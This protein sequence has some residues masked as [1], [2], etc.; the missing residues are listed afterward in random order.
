MGRFN[1][2]SFG[3]VPRDVMAE[4]HRLQEQCEDDPDAWIG[5]GYRA[6]VQE[7]RGVLA[8][9]VGAEEE[10]LVL[11]ENASGGI[12]AFLRSLPLVAGDKILFPSTTYGM[13]KNVLH[14]L[15]DEKG[16]E[17]I[18]VA[19]TDVVESPALLLAEIA[20]AIAAAGGP[21]EI[22][23]G[24]FDH[25]ASI[26]GVVLPVEGFVDL[27][28]GVPVMIDGAHAPGV[29]DLRLEELR[30][31]HLSAAKSAAPGQAGGCYGCAARDRDRTVSA[32]LPAVLPV[33]TVLCCPAC[34]ACCA[35]GGQPP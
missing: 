33:L 24:I 26:P 1:H 30:A 10:D 21:S 12:N 29:L 28:P 11:V 7:A 3:T 16:V 22:A 5:T 27:L 20:A 35:V 13:V 18:E 15:R 34:P 19:I 4:L 9:Y 17:L 23:L 32:V 14:L 6:L 2:G 8:E 31:R 25:I